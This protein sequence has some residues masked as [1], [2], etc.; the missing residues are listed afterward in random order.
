MTVTWETKELGEVAYLAGRIG[1]KG[2][3]A[4]EYT[5]SGP[6]FTS[7]HSLNHGDYVDFSEAF[8]IT[9]E[10]YE[11]SPEIMLESD[12]ILI[13][14]D[15]AGIGKVGIV[16]KLPGPATINSSLLLIRAAKGV[17]P[18]FLYYDLCS[19]SFQKIV[20]D[21]I[22][23][24]TTPHLYQR[25]IRQ[26]PI[27]IP[28]LPEQKRIVAILDDAFAGIAAATANVEKNLANAREL[29]ETHLNS[30]FDVAP[31]HWTQKPMRS[32][33]QI[34][35]GFAFKSEYFTD[36][37]SYV[38]LTPGN[39]YEGGG[40]R[41][42]G[43]KQKFYVGEV[44]DGFVLGKGAFLIA[45]TEQ[46]PGLLGSSIIVPESDKF[47]HN[48]RLGLVCVRPGAPW[49]NEFFFHAFNTR[50]FRLAV[51]D[52]ASGVKVR[53][54]SPDKLG[55][56]EVSFPES[57][58]EQQSIAENLDAL[59][60]ETRRLAGIYNQKLLRLAELK[61]AILQKAFSG[62]LTGLPEEALQEAAA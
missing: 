55:L 8:H 36:A 3:T 6:L 62:E 25:E 4:K 33:V 12:D 17:H 31:D 44:P 51:H 35:H 24:A 18:K 47:L 41:D 40:Y 14:K 9:Q 39:F 22:D 21:K 30:T 15:G 58:K 53:H 38:L 34:K 5:T 42:R 20:Q 49:C 37:G 27:P 11:E 10:R 2:L 7:V 26:F 23:G 29:F 56:V 61:Q 45:M 46:A 57:I 54:T 48:Q 60:D 19:P 43:G 1:W 28:P 59:L 32:L 13:C 16:G 50:R 52:G